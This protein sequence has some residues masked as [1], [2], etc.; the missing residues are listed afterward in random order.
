MT[1][2][3][4]ASNFLPLRLP[5]LAVLLAGI[6][7]VFAGP[8]NLPAGKATPPVMATNSAPV[9]IPLTPSVFATPGMVGSGKDPFFPKSSRFNVVSVVSTNRATPNVVPELSLN[10]ISGTVARP[11]AIIN[12][13]TF[14]AGEDGEVVTAAGNRVRVLCVEIRFEQ[15]TVIVEVGGVRREL[16]FRGRK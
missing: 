11:L 14:S 3:L 2:M 13:R 15:N 10:G 5:I 16:K 12:S 7:V 9:E 1:M 4:R 8:T 6:S